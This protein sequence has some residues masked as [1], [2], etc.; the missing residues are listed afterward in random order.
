MGKKN[1][2]KRAKWK[3]F[4]RDLTFAVLVISGLMYWQTKDMLNSDGSVVV[5]QQNMIT[6]DGEVVPL[7]AKDKTNILYFFAPWCR[8][9]ALSIGNLSYLDPEKVNVVV[10]ALDFGSKQEVQQFVEQHQ[11]SA[12]VLMGHEALKSQFQIQGYPS[13]YVV[14]DEQVIKSRVFGYSTAIGLKLRE[15]FQ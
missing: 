8:I 3:I 2:T 5:Q 11:V 6:L 10:I 15:L 14:D 9:C 13:Y 7:L 4:A 1:L 12:N